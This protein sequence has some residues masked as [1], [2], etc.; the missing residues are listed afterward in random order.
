MPSGTRG[1][2]SRRLLPGRELPTPPTQD[3]QASSSEPARTVDEAGTSSTIPMTPFDSSQGTHVA[4][5]SSAA[6]PDRR[7]LL[8]IRGGQ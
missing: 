3:S 1:G 4:S 5:A 2:S 7:F 8:H 6:T